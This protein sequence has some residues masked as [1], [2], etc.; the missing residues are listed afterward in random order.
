MTTNPKP[1]LVLAVGSERAFE[2]ARDALR[3]TVRLLRTCPAQV[4]RPRKAGADPALANVRFERARVLRLFRAWNERPCPRAALFVN[5]PRLARE[6]G[7]PVASE[8]LRQVVTAR[9]IQER[10]VSRRSK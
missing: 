1:P 10:A 3:G 7:E 8:V 4:P 5:V 2:L 6:Y 9:V